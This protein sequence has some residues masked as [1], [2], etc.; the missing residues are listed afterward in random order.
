MSALLENNITTVVM[1]LITIYA[2][3]GDDVRVLSTDKHGDP[4][5]WI[6]N[7]IAMVFFTIE[8]VIS[9]LIKKDY[10][11]GFFFWLDTISTLSLFLDIGWV[12]NKLF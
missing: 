4:V 12:S 2:L 11:L 8:I 10:F 3:F 1:T 7:I 6:L 5:F 9:C